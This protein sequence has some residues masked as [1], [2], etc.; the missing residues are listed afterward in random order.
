MPGALRSVNQLILQF[1]TPD[2]GQ[3]PKG[4]RPGLENNLH[5]LPQKSFV[6]G[7]SASR[8]LIFRLINGQ[9]Q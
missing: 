4:V 1:S 8:L 2:Y 5:N 3:S 7:R 9:S 6:Y